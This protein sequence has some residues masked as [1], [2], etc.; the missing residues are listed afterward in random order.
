MSADSV[1]TV[2]EAADASDDYD[3]T[4]E[5]LQHGL[6]NAPDSVVLLR[7]LAAT[8][9]DMRRHSESLEVLRRAAALASDDPDVMLELGHAL[10]RD[11]WLPEALDV[12]RRLL[13]RAPS[14]GAR[15]AVAN[16]LVLLGR[17][18][19]ALSLTEETP[20]DRAG[21]EMRL[22]RA[23]VLNGLARHRDALQVLG[24]LTE[25]QPNYFPAWIATAEAHRGM[26]SDDW[27]AAA[28]T[29]IAIEPDADLSLFW[30]ARIAID[31]DNPDEAITLLEQAIAIHPRYYRALAQL[32]I[33]CANAERLDDAARA[34]AEAVTIAPWDDL[35]VGAQA[36]FLVNTGRG[37]PDL[38]ALE[39]RAR[40]RPHS[41]LAG[42]L[43][44]IYR[45]EMRDNQRSLPMLQLAAEHSPDGAEDHRLYGAALLHARR[46][47][48][49]LLE[50]QRAVAIN[51]TYGEALLGLG[52]A[53]RAL[54]RSEEALVP[55]HRAVEL[56]PIHAGAFHGLGLALIETGRNE[57]AIAELAHAVQFGPQVGIYHQA[58]AVAL[59]Q[60]GRYAE[61]QQVARTAKALLPP[62]HAAQQQLA[63]ILG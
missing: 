22:I 44:R 6:A 53:L 9:G 19:E 37:D 16:D 26:A 58:L 7:K 8:W 32:G 40:E 63:Q 25:A 56:M 29:A 57:E 39:Q 31:R 33:V 18:E 35:C 11:S 24:P 21:R 48:E 15:A 5:I 23:R 52:M 42:Y 14:L 17:P 55:L 34:L 27:I 47:D 54:R 36:L 4:V 28:T 59:H 45:Y 20:S 38:H 10:R 62:D 49:A 30:R 50:L 46:L 13:D 41:G 61:A 51:P 1:R 2:L 43:G 3:E 60:A 12:H